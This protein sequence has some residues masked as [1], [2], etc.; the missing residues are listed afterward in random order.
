MESPIDI[1]DKRFH[2]ST[3]GTCDITER[4]EF[5]MKSDV[6][7]PTTATGRSA[8]RRLLVDI[9]KDWDLYLALLPGIAF[10]ILF[11]YTPMYGIIIAFKDFNIFEGMAA[12]PWVGLKHFEKLFGSV[13]F[14]SV[15][16]N[17]LIISLY[18]I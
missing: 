13:S 1:K 2:A 12:S 7:S 18:K 9:R 3:I 5:V 4:G 17:T 14:M 10:L 8:R 15:F 11:K 6:S 16:R